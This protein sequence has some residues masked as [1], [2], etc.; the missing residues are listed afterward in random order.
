M[1]GFPSMK[2][3]CRLLVLT[4]WLVVAGPATAM[5]NI[6]E[7]GRY[8]FFAAGCISCHT[9]DEALAGGRP[10][11]SPYGIFY[12]P[13][14]TPSVKHGIGTWKNTDLERA[15]RQGISPQGEHYYPAFPYPSFTR[16]TPEDIQALYAYLMN[17]Q[18]SA[19]QNQAHELYWP[20]SSRPLLSHWKDRGFS[21]GAFSP[22]P[23][24]SAQWNRGAYLASALGHCSECH[25]PR[26]F[27]GVPRS[28]LY[29]A[30]ACSDP[31]GDKVPNITPD[32]E[33]GIGNWTCNDLMHF[34]HSGR[35]PDGSFAGGLMTEVLATSCMPLT[36]YDRESLAFYLKTVP[37]V[38]RNLGIL[39]G[40][41]DDPS[42]YD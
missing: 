42:M 25:T 9:A 22:D 14:I 24:R 13:N 31:Q 36:Q 21:P 32:H 26:G 3:L 23:A 27:L 15:L 28:D 30:G 34:L 7:H 10:I 4:A 20:Y 41:F 37:P 17:Q 8:V 40:P 2:R 11:E 39:C 19:R 18:V 35:K 1:T 12:P 5:D 16:M 38:H 33:T 29:L 6:A